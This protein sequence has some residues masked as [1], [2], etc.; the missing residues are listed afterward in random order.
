MLNNFCLQDFIIKNYEISKK[1]GVP[2]TMHVA[3]MDYELAKYKEE[4]NLT[5]VQYLN[6]LGILDSNFI[7]A[8][9]VLVDDDDIR[10][11][12][13]NG[14]DALVVIGGDGSFMGA[15][16]LSKLGVKTIGL[17]G[18]IDNLRIQTRNR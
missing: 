3:E 8:H 1:Y 5:P 11:L 2:M 12:K 7:S 13:E 16:L 4:Y 17:T 10:I 9:T 6:K 14:V 15:K 18:T